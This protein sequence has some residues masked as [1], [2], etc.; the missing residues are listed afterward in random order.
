MGGDSWSVMR[1]FACLLCCVMLEK[2]RKGKGIA[3]IGIRSF[4]HSF[5]HLECSIIQSSFSF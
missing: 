4:V 2:E 5:I 3:Y 1:F